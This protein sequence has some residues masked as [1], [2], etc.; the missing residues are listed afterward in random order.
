MESLASQAFDVALVDI[1]MPKMSGLTLFR[2]M[3]ERYRDVA[4]IFVTAMDDM[5]LALEQ[6]KNGA[7]DYIVKPVTQKR[8]LQVVGEALEKRQAL[9]Q[10]DHASN[11][12]EERLA[13]QSRELEDRAREL[14]SLNQMFQADLTEEFTREE[15]DEALR[16]GVVGFIRRRWRKS[17]LRGFAHRQEFNPALQDY[18]KGMAWGE[19]FR[20]ASNYV[21]RLIMW[22]F[23]SEILLIAG[24]LFLSWGLEDLEARKAAFAAG[25][26]L[27]GWGVALLTVTGIAVWIKASTD[28]VTDH[29]EGR[30]L[31]SLRPRELQGNG[32]SLEAEQQTHQR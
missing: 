17:V 15:E 14:S 1:V 29:V 25:I 7:Y 18:T 3:R 26:G 10:Q 23:L 32:S 13:V 19:A 12:A 24:V 27:L 4:V 2:H 30:T 20:R 8:L 31:A 21:V 16:R 6:L 11:L 9:L 22:A 28:A 5:N